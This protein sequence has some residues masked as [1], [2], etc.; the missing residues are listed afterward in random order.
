MSA[1]FLLAVS[2]LE[3]VLA[4]PIAGI[5]RRSALLF[6]ATDSFVATTV[7][8]LTLV[9]ILPHTVRVAGVSALGVAALGALL[10]LLLHVAFHRLERRAL[11]I[12]AWLVLGALAFHAVLDGA[13]LAAPDAAHEVHADHDHE[14]MST[15]IGAAV[16]LHRFPMVL[17]I[18]WFALPLLGRRAA[19]AL[20]TALG[21]GTLA[22]F[23]AAEASWAAL[24]SRPI[25]L[26][27][28]LVAGM[29]FHVLIGHEG[30]DDARN[31]HG[32]RRWAIVIGSLVA[33]AVTVTMA[34]LG[35]LELPAARPLSALITGGVSTLVAVY[36][37]QARWRQ[38][39]EHDHGPGHSHSY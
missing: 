29:L 12:L 28:A 34:I 8:A 13:A 15:L 22:G 24:G 30:P 31:T 38:R 33:L 21:L 35:T 36:V 20:L 7:G 39:H 26:V 25:A 17:G 16:V 3:V 10:P 1:S 2:L 5:A 19:I 9:H 11:P 27:Q 32:Q 4:P 37:I 18:W 23:F 6:A 14:S